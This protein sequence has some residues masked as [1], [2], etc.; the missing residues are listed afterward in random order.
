MILSKVID[1]SISVP[2][3][4]TLWLINDGCELYIK[5]NVFYIR[6]GIFEH[7]CL[8]IYFGPFKS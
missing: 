6:K 7:I 2:K 3:I 8:M 1:K 5:V 4:H